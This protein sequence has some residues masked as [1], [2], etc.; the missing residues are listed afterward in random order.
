MSL[1]NSHLSVA[2]IDSLFVRKVRWWNSSSST[3]ATEKTL[4]TETWTETVETSEAKTK[5]TEATEEKKKTTAKKETETAQTAQYDHQEVS[6]PKDH[7][8]AK[9]GL[10]RLNEK[11]CN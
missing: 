11:S 6:R 9:R 10:V 4:A 1:N 7:P 3:E 8:K 5:T 2:K